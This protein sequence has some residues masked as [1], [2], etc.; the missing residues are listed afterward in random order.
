MK[1][2]PMLFCLLILSAAVGCGESPAEAPIRPVRAIKFGDVAG[3]ESEWFPGRARATE[4]VNLSFRVAGELVALPLDVGD[5]VA[6][7]DILARLDPRDFEAAHD[8]AGA[9]LAQAVAE[10]AAMRTARPEEIRRLEAQ[11]KEFE[12]ILALAETDYRRVLAIQAE[13][14]GAVAQAEVDRKRGIRDR[15]AASL[16][17]AEELLAIAREGARREDI[18]AKEAET[19]ALAAEVVVAQNKVDYTRLAAPF[20]GTI[21]ATYVEN[22]QTVVA[23][24]A[25]CR[26]LDTSRIEM[27]VNIPESRISM[28]PFIT[29]VVCVF[30]VFPDMPIPAQVKEVGTEASMTTRTYPVTVIMEQPDGAIV[31]PGMAGKVRGRVAP[32][33]GSVEQAYALPVNAVF[34]PET[35]RQSCVW[36]VDESS[37]TVKRRPIETGALTPTGVIVT[38]G[39]TS[40]EWIVTAG[41]H[42]LTDG[43]QVRLLEEGGS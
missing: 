34:T 37:L 12:A 8:R 24:Q 41:V 10:L 43:Q 14:R 19:R 25:V 26:L 27:V 40:G 31:L 18:A 28:A 11:V 30:D 22:Y 7:G 20:G 29:D 21:V 38:G 13:D 6:K 39:L 42:S 9:K 33:E 23:R 3:V 1:S 16:E 5:V 4:E 17:Q 35:E 32:A 2:R 15:S 36:V